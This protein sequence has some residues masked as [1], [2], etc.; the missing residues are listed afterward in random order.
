[1][2]FIEQRIGYFS[3]TFFAP[4]QF[5]NDQTGGFGKINIHMLYVVVTLYTRFAQRLS[6]CHR[7]QLQREM[8]ENIQGCL[9]SIDRTSCC[10]LKHHALDR[11]SRLLQFHG[12]PSGMLVLHLKPKVSSLSLTPARKNIIFHNQ[13]LLWQRHVVTDRR[14]SKDGI[15]ICRRNPQ[16]LH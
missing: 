5:C 10:S 13:L 8:L 11:V 2:S 3:S 12:H 15:C 7:C 9:V 4:T 16:P 6:L 1:M 14:A